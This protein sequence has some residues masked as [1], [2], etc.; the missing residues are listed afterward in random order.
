MRSPRVVFSP[1]VLAGTLAIVLPLVSIV[2]RMSRARE[3]PMARLL[4]ADAAFRRINGAENP[5]HCHVSWYRASIRAAAGVRRGKAERR[6]SSQSGFVA[7]PARTKLQNP[8]DEW[9]ATPRIQIFLPPFRESHPVSR[10]LS[11][12]SHENPRSSSPR[13]TIAI[14]ARFFFFLPK[15]YYKLSLRVTFGNL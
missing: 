6:E 10:V 9:R 3:I 11:R 8:P 5:I 4:S 1:L 13:L 2:G 15:N 7:A 14:C 12:Q